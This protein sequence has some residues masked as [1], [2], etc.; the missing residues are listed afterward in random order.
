NPKSLG[1]YFAD[2]AILKIGQNLKFDVKFVKHNYNWE[3]VNLADTMIIEQVIR[4][5]LR[6]RASMAA[7]ALYYLRLHLDKDKDLRLSFASTKI[8]CFSKRQLDYAAG[9]CVYPLYILQKQKQIIKE[10]GLVSTVNLEHKVLPVLAKAE[11]EGMKM[12]T[13]SWLKLYQNSVRKKDDAEAQLDVF[14]GTENYRQDD[15]FGESKK[16]KNVNYDSPDQVLNLLKLRKYDIESTDK[17]A[18]I[19]AYIEKRLP[20]KFV[21]AML[22]FRMYT[23]RISRYGLNMLQAIEPS[24]NHIHT[25]FLQANTATGRLSSGRATGEEFGVKTQVR[26]GEAKRINFQNLPRLDEYRTCFV[27]D[28]GYKLVVLDY[29]AIEPRILAQQSSDP[30]YVRTFK[31]DLDIYQEIGEEIYHEEVSKKPGRPAELRDKAK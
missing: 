9:D 22:L 25:E 14:F 7:L 4:C 8:G 18:L 24:T 2:P 6:L 10:R 29:S 17:N 23:T 1:P 31:N 12:D 26:S 30:M 11:L 27:A 16:Q 13:H 28:K 3:V 19:L 5:G 20:K 21:Q 15:F